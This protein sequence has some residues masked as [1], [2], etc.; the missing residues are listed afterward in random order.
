MQTVKEV[1]MASKWNPRIKPQGNKSEYNNN[2]DEKQDKIRLKIR[3]KIKSIQSV[4]TAR[5]QIIL[6]VNAFSN[7]KIIK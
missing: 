4:D 5:R 2:R 6:S 7:R 1:A 3:M